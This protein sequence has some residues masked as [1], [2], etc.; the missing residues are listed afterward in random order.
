M[1]FYSVIER[2]PIEVKKFE[3]VKTKNNRNMAVGQDKKGNK[4]YKFVSQSI[5]GTK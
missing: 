1:K 5:K 2:K 4:V 3:V